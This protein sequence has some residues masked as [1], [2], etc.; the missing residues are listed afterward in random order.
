RKLASNSMSAVIGLVHDSHRIALLPGDLDELGLENLL[1]DQGN[2]EASVLIFPHHGGS[3][4]SRDNYNF[5][6]KL[7]SLVNPRLVIFSFERGRLY[8]K[9]RTENPRDDIMR[10]IISSCPNAHIMCTQL[11]GKCAAKNPNSDFSHLTNLPALGSTNDSCC[12]GTM[13]I[14]INGNQTTYSP[15]R[16]SHAAFISDSSNVPTP[17]CLL[18]FN[19]VQI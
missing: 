18:H 17:M 8:G 2:I 14:R 15:Q 7:C 9:H 11:S 12:G 10:G 4:N 3:A 5:S 1:M 16:S 13:R 6:R 19:E